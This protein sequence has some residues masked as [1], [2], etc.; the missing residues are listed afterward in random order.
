MTTNLFVIFG[1]LM[2]FATVVGIID[3]IG[4]RQERKEREERTL[5]YSRK[6]V[7]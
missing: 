5:P 3:I 6:A 7:P 4:R 1:G 2:L